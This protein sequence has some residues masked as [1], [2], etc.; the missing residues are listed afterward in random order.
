MFEE[1]PA[2]TYIRRYWSTQGIEVVGAD[3]RTI[4]VTLGTDV[5]DLSA[6]IDD[7]SSEFGLEADYRYNAESKLGTL[8]L[9]R[10]QNHFDQLPGG[11]GTSPPCSYSVFFACT[12]VA[13]SVL[14]ALLLHANPGPLPFFGTS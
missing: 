7:L 14:S 8:V 11:P 2:V 3:D 6:F 10:A 4:T 1:L 13:L 9:T 5:E 12:T